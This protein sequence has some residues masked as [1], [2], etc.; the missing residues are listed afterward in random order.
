MA[1]HID[2]LKHVQYLLFEHDSVTIP[3][4]GTFNKAER[5]AQF[6]ADKT[7]LMPP[8]STLVFKDKAK[9]NDG[10]LVGHI[11]EVEELPTYA[12]EEAITLYVQQ[13]LKQLRQG[14]MVELGDQIGALTMD[15]ESN[16][17]Y[18]QSP[19]G[20][21]FSLDNYGLSSLDLP[22]TEEEIA[23]SPEDLENVP[24]GTSA[25]SRTE[26]LGDYRDIT[27]D[28]EEEEAAAMALGTSVGGGYV[29]EKKAVSDVLE[30]RVSADNGA[31][32]AT[33][34]PPKKKKASV[35]W[36]WIIPL[37]ILLLFV[38]LIL[39]VLNSDSNRD[40]YNNRRSADLFD[41]SKEK[42][43]FIAGDNEDPNANGFAANNGGTA[44]DGTDLGS[45]QGEPFVTNSDNSAPEEGGIFGGN[46]NN[47][48][49]NGGTDNNFTAI[50]ESRASDNK[51]TGGGEAAANQG[52]GTT[53]ENNRSLAANLPPVR[54]DNSSSTKKE[55]T[56]PGSKPA[57]KT[58]SSS[59]TAKSSGKS[60]ASKSRS[61]SK[62][63]KSSTKATTSKK[64]SSRNVN[65]TKAN[66]KEYAANKGLPRGY[67]VI[68]GAFRSKPNARKL[69]KK[70]KREG[71]D[72]RILETASGFYR[73]GIY[74]TKSKDKAIK[75]FNI[76]KRKHNQKAWIL[77]YN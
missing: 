73:T 12:V 8:V 24:I 7:S 32:L 36:R 75:Q 74:T 29:Q 2:I 48:G 16:A 69:E 20:S 67:Y 13:I 37:A 49:G 57:A 1:A 50:T 34:A 64:S 4:L 17:I 65:I 68:I 11:C 9:L 23:T 76:S 35:L 55:T 27:Y 62:S 41:K 26:P 31:A 70:L 45:E 56:K 38:L 21:N 54:P 52:G 47:N 77:D 66:S 58:A 14:S 71:Y 5:P 40:N 43:A 53:D 42:E 25:G 30:E 60:A 10:L 61:A 19:D 44:K 51:A 18:L 39:Q 46:G 63:T 22:P 72:A 3:G 15:P 28:P 6:S 33:T 59:S